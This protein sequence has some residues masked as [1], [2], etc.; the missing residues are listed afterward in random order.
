[1]KVLVVGA[2]GYLGSRIAVES[3][4]RGHKVTAL[5]SEGSQSK[6][7]DI[8]Q[9][10]RDT[11]I[12]TATGHLESKQEILVK[13]LTDVNIVVS[14]VNG[15][16]LL[17]QLN[18]VEAAKKAANPTLQ[19]LPS[20]FSAFGA[21]GEEAAPLLYGPKAQVRRALQASHIRYTFIVAYG[22]APYWANGLGELGTRGRVP[23]APRGLDKVP[24]YG[25]GHT[26]FCVNTV[27]DVVKYTVRALG[28][29]YVVN[30]QLHIRP[31]LN[32]VSQHDLIH[33]Y[34]DKL[35]R[36]QG[37][38]QRLV[39]AP[40]S[41]ADLDAQITGAADDIKRTQLQLQKSF[42]FMGTLTPLGIHD[43]EA[44]A[45]YPDDHHY[46]PI[47]RYMNNLIYECKAHLAEE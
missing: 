41:E 7:A 12:E 36:Q 14:A 4:R 27:E 45:L 8:V 11:G 32:Q 31:R 17:L 44:T 46:T 18:L 43:Y 33:I 23:P 6:K 28:C 19:F 39:R 42:I 5:V 24:Y 37:I 22:L 47:A 40:V 16:G 38:G 10:L 15:P 13:L 20:E 29:S 26:R 35:F 9:R 30:K 3:A 2:T 25:S 1:M 21:V 34:E